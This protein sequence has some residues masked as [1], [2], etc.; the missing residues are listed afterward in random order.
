VV[1]DWIIKS[2]FLLVGM[3]E[4]YRSIGGFK[5]RDFSGDAIPEEWQLICNLREVLSLFLN[6]LNFIFTMGWGTPLAM[7]FQRSG[8]LCVIF[9][10]CLLLLE[11]R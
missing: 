1:A 10:V 2:N 4:L 11:K 5:I 6:F 9:I 7:Q 8:S 3:K